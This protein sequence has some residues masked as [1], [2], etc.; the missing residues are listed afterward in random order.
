MFLMAVAGMFAFTACK[1]NSEAPAEDSTAATMEQM[2]EPTPA[3]V[4]SAAM[5]DTTAAPVQ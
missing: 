3:P 5:V 4:D 2:A 1:N